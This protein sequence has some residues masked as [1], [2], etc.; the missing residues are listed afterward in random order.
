MNEPPEQ[1]SRV[2]LAVTMGDPAGIGPEVALKAIGRRR[3]AAHVEPFSSVTWRCGRKRPPGLGLRPAPRRVRKPAGHAPCASSH[4]DAAGALSRAWRA[5][6][7]GGSQRVR[8]GGLRGD[9]RSGAP[10]ASRR[11]CRRG[12]GADQQGAPGGGGSRL[13]GPHRAAG[14]ARRRCAGAHDDGRARAC[15]SC[16]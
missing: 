13:P 15:G 10:R 5:A 14:G 1:R 6:R 9:P 8:R 16:W 11:R 4:V 12:D 3:C 7:A 2:R